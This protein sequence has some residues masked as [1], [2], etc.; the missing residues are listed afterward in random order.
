[1]SPKLRSYLFLAMSLLVALVCWRLGLWQVHRLAQR[2][3]RNRAIFAARALS[4]VSLD[5]PGR[6]A[7]AAFATGT[8]ADRLVRVTGRYDHAGDLVL[9][10]QSIQGVPAVK[11]VTPFRPLLGDSAVLVVRG[12]VPSPDAMTVELDSLEEP[13]IHLVRGYAVLLDSSPD[14]G[15]PVE[16]GGLLTLRRLDL[17]L[18]RQRFPFPLR[19]FA[20]NQLPDSTLPSLPRRVPPPELD[21][22]PYLSYAVQWFGFGVIAVIVG[23]LVG[24]RRK[25]EARV[26]E[27]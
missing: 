15:I 1:M 7:A 9:R 27:R 26:G 25:G 6:A 8:L 13:G 17:P 22:G 23:G 11:V 21:D 10:E 2:R 24:F 4:P 18:L 5:D 12:Y 20:I 14:H 19:S 3:A 16:R